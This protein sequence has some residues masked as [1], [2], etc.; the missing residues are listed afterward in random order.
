MP[1]STP[2]RSGRPSSSGPASSRNTSNSETP[3]P[4]LEMPGSATQ[5]RKDR[6]FADRYRIAGILWCHDPLSVSSFLGDEYDSYAAPIQNCTTPDQLASF[7]HTKEIYRDGLFQA[8]IA[9][10]A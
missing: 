5:T 2:P 3:M 10:L 1:A 8:L 6:L 4:Q 7:L 9:Y